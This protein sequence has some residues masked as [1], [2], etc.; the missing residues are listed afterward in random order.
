M[1]RNAMVLAAALLPLLA[2]R[3]V[4]FTEDAHIPDGDATYEGQPVTV[5]GCT[6]TVDGAHVFTN[7]YL[8]NSA[9]LT[10]TAGSAGMTLTVSGTV[11]VATGSKIDVSER[12]LGYLSGTT[13]RSGGSYGGRGQE[14]DGTSC[15]TYGDVFCPTNPGSGGYGNA[16]VICRGGGRVRITAASLLLD[17][18]LRANGET[19]YYY[20]GSY[21]SEYRGAGSGGSILVDVDTLAGN[22]LIHANGGTR[23]GSYVGVGGGGRVAVYYDDASG[24]DLDGIQATGGGN[25][26]AGTVYLKDRAEPLGRLVLDNRGAESDAAIPTPV[27][28]GSNRIDRLFVNGK[29]RLSLTA[30]E[31]LALAQTVITN[32][33][34]TFTGDVTGPELALCDSTWEHAGSFGYSNRVAL[35]G[36]SVLRHAAG[37][38]GGLQIE[39]GTVEVASGSSIDVSERGLDYLSG[40]TGYSGGSHGGRG[41]EYN[42]TSCPTYGD[43]FCPTNLG[44]GG[45]G[46]ASTVRRGGGMLRIMADSLELDGMLRANGAPGYY[47][48]TSP[49]TAVYRGG[50]S[51]GSILLE[52]G[53]L[54]GAGSVSANGGDLNSYG[55]SG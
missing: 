52:V 54:G 47:W 21:G 32:A 6:L 20:S 43:A 45:N 5:S 25:G 12:G 11:S 35:G 30:S 1:K 24:F 49:S 50:G 31:P 14:Y 48:Q 39:C 27:S 2:A 46:S 13:G 38:V 34:V 36:A 17:G 33:S 44:S 53:A 19:A 51:G 41:Q 42:G 18:E 55:R 40:T 4:T 22:G 28:L 15:A 7:L 29:A 16:S 26:G 10:H 9:T 8:V 23:P 37:L 3:A